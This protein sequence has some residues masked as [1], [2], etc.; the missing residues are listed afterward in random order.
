MNDMDKP[1][2]RIVEAYKAAVYAKDVAAF[3]RLYDPA[4]RVFDT[5]GLWSYEKAEAWQTAVEGWFTSLGTER[6][7]VRFD[8]L[9]TVGGPDLA[10]VTAIVAYEGVS[11]EGAPLRA[12]QNR[13][14]WGLRTSGHVLRIVHEHTSAPIG[15][16]DSK[17]ILQRP[18]AG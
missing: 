18:S 9:R 15:F 6:V 7:K 8:D 12:M 17:A 1:V 14:T 5:W 11:A 3:V 13:L 10:I 2:G 4:V 16:E